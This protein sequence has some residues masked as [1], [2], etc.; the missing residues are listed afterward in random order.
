MVLPAG[1]G[2]RCWTE[3]P[4]DHLRAAGAPELHHRPQRPKLGQLAMPRLNF[5]ERLMVALI[6]LAAIVI[7]LLFK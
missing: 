1:D 2:F 6:I 5:P 4:G 3:C 7:P